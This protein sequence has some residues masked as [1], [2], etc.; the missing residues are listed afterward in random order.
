MIDSFYPFSEN[1][2]LA[3]TGQTIG[4]AGLVLKLRNHM[5]NAQAGDRDAE[6][7]LVNRI[8]QIRRSVPQI[9]EI[10]PEVRDM[11]K[12]CVVFLRSVGRSVKLDESDPARW[13]TQRGGSPRW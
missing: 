3:A 5:R 11:L 10:Q 12:E 4:L 1:V 6:S 9:G 2:K 13:I 7:R 8:G